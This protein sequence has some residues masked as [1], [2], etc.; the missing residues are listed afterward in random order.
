MVTAAFFGRERRAAAARGGCVW[1]LDREP[2]ASHR[3]YEVDFGALE[4]SDADRI[5]EETNAVRFEYLVALPSVLFDHQPVLESRTPSAL[6]EHAQTAVLLLLFGEKLGDFG[7]CRGRN[8]NHVVHSLRGNDDPAIEI[9]QY[10]RSCPRF[11]GTP[12]G[13]RQ[14]RGGPKFEQFRPICTLHLPCSSNSCNSRW[15]LPN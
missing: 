7:G 4:V 2:T 1:I 11:T 10:A 9:I 12:S 14:R 5:D 8:V 6:H 15:T 13:G 3:I